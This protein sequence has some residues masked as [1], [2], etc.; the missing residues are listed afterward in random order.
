M[1]DFWQELRYGVRMLRKSPGFTAVAVILATRVVFGYS[2]GA[3]LFCAPGQ[4]AP[5]AALHPPQF[6]LPTLVAPLR[7]SVSLTLAPDQD[8]F[9]GQV[10]IDLNFKEA[11][12][13]LWLNADKI[14][15]KDAA[16]TVGGRTLTAKAITQPKDLE[17]F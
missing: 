10:D 3:A 2:F 4:G 5:N 11:S 1:A 9:T 13:V 15:V 6:R 7:Y 14:T 8:T 16:L 17:G 12:S